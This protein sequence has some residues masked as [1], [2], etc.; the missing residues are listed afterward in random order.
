MDP[1]ATL[2]LFSSPVAPRSTRAYLHSDYNYIQILD[3]NGNPL[4]EF[5]LNC[6]APWGVAVNRGRVAVADTENQR[7]AI[8]TVDYSGASPVASFVF[9]LDAKGARLPT[10]VVDRWSGQAWIGQPV[11]DDRRLNNR[12]QRFHA[13]PGNQQNI[14]QAAAPGRGADGRPRQ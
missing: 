7:I 11:P 9:E 13:R 10:A 1:G 5:G 12:V 6:N 2:G 8:F 4:S 3:P 14:D